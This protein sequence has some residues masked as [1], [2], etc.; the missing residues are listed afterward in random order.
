MS[1]KI[2]SVALVGLEAAQVEVEAGI[3]PSL[4]AFTIV[5]LPDTAVQE[6]RERV[7]LAIRNSGLEFP[8]MKIT[9]NLAPADLKK[10]GPGY[11]LPVALAV[12]LASEQ[13]KP[14]AGLGPNFFGRFLFLGELA[15]DGRLRPVSGILPAAL[16]A[17]RSKM[18]GIFV[19]EQNAAEAALIK[20]IKV[21]PVRDLRGLIEHIRAMEE[22]VPAPPTD[23]AP[24]AHEFEVDMAYIAGQDHA[25]RALTIAAAGHHNVLMSGPP[26]SGKTLLARAAAGILP[27][28]SF[29]E[30]IDVTRIYSIAGLLPPGTPLITKRPY[31]AP[32]HSASSAALIGGGSQVKP[33]EI[34]L[35]HRGVLF[36]DEIVE[37]HRDVLESLREPLETGAIT[38]SRASGSLRFPAKVMLVAAR[39]PC[40]CGYFGDREKPCTCMPGQIAK[41]SKKLSG[42][43]SDRIDLHIEVPRLKFDKLTE[44]RVATPSSE[45]RAQI[46]TAREIQR[47]RFAGRNYGTN[48]EMPVQDIKTFCAVDA[49]TQD[50]L[51]NAV[52]RLHLSA[53][54]YHRVLKLSRTIADLVGAPSI[55]QGHVAEALQYRPRND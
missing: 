41:Y 47:E 2:L 33:G 30:M 23:I 8:P 19:P 16:F 25:K 3:T 27:P 9:V 32:H 46:E 43:I 34:T 44:E 37:F 7:R 15:L 18:E 12:L 51:R 55:A 17:A 4:T 29:S 22:I 20:E 38:I 52:D 42:P 1:T 35:A 39:N 10:E 5:G 28:M 53:R 50:I 45:I 36:L 49:S 14:A 13:L 24:T 11:D 48:A 40:P 54:A 26:G 21:Y 31:R 6:A